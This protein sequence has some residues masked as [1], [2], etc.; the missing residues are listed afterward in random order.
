MD[1]WRYQYSARLALLLAGGALWAGVLVC[2]GYAQ[3]AT[4]RNGAAATGGEAVQP[5]RLAVL[6]FELDEVHL[7]GAGGGREQRGDRRA[8][9]S[10]VD[11][12]F[13]LI[14]N[15]QER[16]RARIE[17]LL[18][19]G[20][21]FAVL[22]RRAPEVHE[23]EKRLL[24]SSDVDPAEAARLGKVLGADHMLYGIVDRV[25]VQEQRT[26]IQLTG[27][28]NTRL[29]ATGR[30]RFTVLAVAT[31]Q[32]VWSSSLELERIV[33]DEVRPE[34]VVEGLLAELAVHIAGEVT[35]SIFPPVVTEVTGSGSFVVNRGANTVQVDDRFEVFARGDML[36]DPDTGTDLGRLEST[37]GIARITAVKPRYSL[38]QMITEFAGIAR[39]M[40]LRRLHGEVGPRSAGDRSADERN[41]RRIDGDR[42]RDGIPD[43]LNRD[44]QTG[45]SN[46][47][48]LPDYLNRDNLRRR[49]E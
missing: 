49:A 16:F 13:A 31:R 21:R 5:Y 15:L 10:G 40:L 18:V 37:V 24:R 27:E 33:D 44:A 47:D 17:E 19:Q 4:E 14:R 41:Y 23:Q 46:N 29:V 3:T 25:E 12:D 1:R 38:A 26:R 39:G 48:G 22:D 20:Q 32:I 30:V 43:Y 7:Y 6:D 9:R 8:V 45:D 34:R 28:T 36:V 35:E 42:D 2:G 11:L